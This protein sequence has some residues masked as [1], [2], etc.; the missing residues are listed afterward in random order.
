MLIVVEEHLFFFWKPFCFHFFDRTFIYIPLVF[1]DS[2][3]RLK[4]LKCIAYN[5][6]SRSK[7]NHLN[8][9]NLCSISAINLMVYSFCNLCWQLLVGRTDHMS[10]YLGIRPSR[11]EFFF[12]FGFLIWISKYFTVSLRN[13]RIVK[14]L[15]KTD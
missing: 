14:V 5:W 9:C 2:L 3:T 11:L 1:V 13:C 12:H 8:K 7:A 4:K 6:R 15:S 10:N